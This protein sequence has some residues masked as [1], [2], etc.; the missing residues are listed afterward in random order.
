MRDGLALGGLLANL[1]VEELGSEV[2]SV[3]PGEGVQFGVNLEAAEVGGVLQWFKHGTVEFTLQ[4]D[5]ALGPVLE[6][7]TQDEP[8][9]ICC[10]DDSWDRHDRLFQWWYRFQGFSGLG[11]F[12]VLPKGVLVQS[13]PLQDMTQGPGRK[14]AVHNAGLDFDG[15]FVV[16]LHRV[17]VRRRVIPVEHSNHNSEEATDLWHMGQC[18]HLRGFAQLS[19]VRGARQR[20]KH[21]GSGLRH[22]RRPRLSAYKAGV[23]SHPGGRAPWRGP[24]P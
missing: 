2:G 15:D 8:R 17:K 1:A 21:G 16:P 5:R 20:V 3:F 6:V 14:G 12:P 10:V 19:Y 24:W 11:Q 4:S 9:D 18:T 13:V 23:N 7:Q 22:P